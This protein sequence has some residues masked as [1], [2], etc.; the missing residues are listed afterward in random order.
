[1]GAEIEELRK[2]AT[3]AGRDPDSVP[4][5]PIIDPDNGNLSVDMLKR[6]QDVGVDGV[7]VFNQQMGTGDRRRKSTRMARPRGTNCGPSAGGVI[8]TRPI[9]ESCVC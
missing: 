4:V 5:T 3:E 9:T 8:V 7:V 6:Y 1:M 2:L